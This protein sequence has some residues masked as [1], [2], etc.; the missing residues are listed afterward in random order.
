MNEKQDWHPVDIVMGLRKKGAAMA[1]LSRSAGPSSS[2]LA[3]ALIRPWTK[4]EEQIA[5]ALGIPPEDIWPSR[6]FAPDGMRIARLRRAGI[7]VNPL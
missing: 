1:A 5:G 6:Y 4:G 3:N 2:I 7:P